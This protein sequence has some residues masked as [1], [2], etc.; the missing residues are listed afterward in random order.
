MG[1]Q[2]LWVPCVVRSDLILGD[3]PQ[4]LV[5][6]SLVTV[7]LLLGGRVLLS[8]VLLLLIQRAD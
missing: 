2:V 1:S 6:L 7:L 5:L 3:L 4:L 8:S